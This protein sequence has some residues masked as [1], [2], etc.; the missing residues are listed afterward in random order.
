MTDSFKALCIV[1]MVYEQQFE[2]SSG[3][4]QRRLNRALLVLSRAPAST[5]HFSPFCTTTHQGAPLR[6]LLVTGW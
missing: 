2:E 1:I 5:C 4:T 6:S 3:G